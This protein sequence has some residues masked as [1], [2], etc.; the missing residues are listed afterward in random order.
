MSIIDEILCDIEKQVKADSNWHVQIADHGKDDNSAE[1][2][3]YSWNAGSH[4]AALA[5][6]D[7]L[8]A[9]GMTDGTFAEP[10]G[11][12]VCIEQLNQDNS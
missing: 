6:K 3:I 2:K 12:F 9:R 7:C 4:M 11:S 5:I 8:V 10:Q 1:R